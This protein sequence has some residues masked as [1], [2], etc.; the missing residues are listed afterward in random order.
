M[1]TL[2]SLH[3]RQQTEVVTAPIPTDEDL[4]S[5]VLCRTRNEVQ[6]LLTQGANPDADRQVGYSA[7]SYAVLHGK[8]DVAKL[9]IDFGADI[10]KRNNDGSTPL[11]MAGFLRGNPRQISEFL[12]N[13]GADIDAVNKD[14]C[15]ALMIAIHNYH[16][17]KAELLV[18]RGADIRIRNRLGKTAYD[19]IKRVRLTET[20]ILKQLLEETD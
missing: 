17:P 9:L 14:G 4:I 16:F 12:L 5:A 8:L 1:G 18:E 19:L 15:T 3:S 2:R 7:L 13:R 20:L 11:M 6:S 10:N